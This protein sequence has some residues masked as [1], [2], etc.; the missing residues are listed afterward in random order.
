[1]RQDIPILTISG[2]DNCGHSGIQSDIKT[3]SDMGCYALTSITSIT[4]QDK[5]KIEAIY[6]L[7]EET[8]IQQTK[9]AIENLHP[10][11]IK[12]GMVRNASTIKKLGTEIVG[13]KNIVCAPGILTSRG[14]KL[15][16]DNALDEIKKHLLPISSIIMLRCNEA[17]LLLDCKIN[18]NDD[19][20]SAAKK[21]QEM[22]A[23]WVLIRGRQ[24]TN[25]MLTALLYGK[26]HIQY[27]SSKNTE[28]WK[29]HGVG[30]AMSAA[31]S[32]NLGKG[33]DML[34]AIKHAHDYLHSQIVY[35]VTDDNQM[36]PADIYGNFMS[37]VVEN[38]KTAH[39]VQFYA[40][41]LSISTRYLSRITGKTVKKTPKEVIDDYLINESK[42][43]LCNSRLT[44]QET[45][46]QAGF[47][48]QAMFCKF[49]K[50]RTGL[51]PSEYRKR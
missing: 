20:E 8:V 9:S 1:M 15:L 42:K 19:H 10:K 39:D 29:R 28:G 6:D 17:E 40:D 4:T 7:P 14:E 41:K 30:G 3:I 44:I 48:S 18:N 5:N 16:D 36:R 43:M 50:K 35:A 24:S 21:L 37:L 34:T 23:E 2:S 27:F 45:A 31:I 25:G 13:C 32:A 38:S 47:T 46:Y 49:F 33:E 26:N 22:G 12:I 11:A 51:S